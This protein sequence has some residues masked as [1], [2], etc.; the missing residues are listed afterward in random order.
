MKEP[1]SKDVGT[2]IFSMDL[3]LKWLYVGLG[4]LHK[5]ANV[6][7]G[8]LHKIKTMDFYRYIAGNG[9]QLNHCSQLQMSWACA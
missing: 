8:T 9:G 5:W 4:T 3:V 2:I 7:F 1:N 6:R